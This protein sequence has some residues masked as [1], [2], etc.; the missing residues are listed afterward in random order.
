MANC[1]REHIIRYFPQV[2][3]RAL[4]RPVAGLPGALDTARCQVPHGAGDGKDAKV[5]RKLGQLQSF[6]AVFPRNAC[7]NLHLL[8]QPNSF[9]AGGRCGGREREAVWAGRPAAAG[10]GASAAPSIGQNS[11]T[12]VDQTR[13]RRGEE[14]NIVRCCGGRSLVVDQVWSEG[15]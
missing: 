14:E 5:A 1:M 2:R 13:M 12:V 6:L 9:V 10:R 4:R 8:G 15:E 11:G 7:A 3:R